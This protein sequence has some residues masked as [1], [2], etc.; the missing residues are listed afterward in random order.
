[1]DS[2]ITVDQIL[3]KLTISQLKHLIDLFGRPKPNA[4]ATKNDVIT[5]I[6]TLN[7]PLDVQ[8]LQKYFGLTDK[9]KK[10]NLT[11]S[12]KKTDVQTETPEIHTTVNHE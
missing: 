8:M 5:H 10:Q 2:N 1:M 11:R 6:N 9:L 3:A 4:K 12:K 7:L